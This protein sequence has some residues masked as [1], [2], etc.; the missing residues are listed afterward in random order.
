M[1]VKKQLSKT[2]AKAARNTTVCSVGIDL[3]DNFSRFC[4]LD[5]DGEVI[6][7]GRFRTTR[8][9]IAGQF[10]GMPT[11]MLIALEAGTHSGWVSRLLQ[12]LGHEVIVANPRDV[13]GIIRSH[14]KSD[15]IDAEK[16]ARYVRVDPSL[17][18]PITHRS[19]AQQLD[20]A[21]IRMRAKFVAARTMLINAARGI[22][23]SLGHRLPGCPAKNF[24]N[25]CKDAVPEPLA[26]TI[27]PLLE[28]IASL[29]EQITAFDLAIENLAR[30]KYPETAP[31]LSVT[32]VGSL[33]AVTFV[34][35]LGDKERFKRSRDVGC[36]LGL[37]PK[38]RQSGD[39][40][41]ELGI[42]KSGN[43]YL[44]TLL[45]QCAQ[46]MLR[47]VTKDSALKRWGLKL[48][49]RSGRNAKKRAVVAVARKLAVLLHRLW[50]TQEQFDPF[51]GCDGSSV[52]SAVA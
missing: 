36:Y 43:R 25:K 5:E 24:P 26:E 17:L 44:R 35:T 29:T 52:A 38:R 2:A 22:V 34:L 3:G 32:G 19:E 7:E 13:V 14:N 41:P 50:K 10:E 28:Q 27:S 15:R 6:Q 18:N 47:T 42:T 31:L 46:H 49:G 16:L 51:Y 37:R 30:T 1:K 20:L 23:K 12:D 45:I 11:P 39:S 4:M 9:S 8:E 21:V 33:S 40:D 48:A